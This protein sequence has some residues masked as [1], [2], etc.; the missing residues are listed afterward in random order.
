MLL[1]K[2]DSNFGISL[3]LLK[4]INSNIKINIEDNNKEKKKHKII[5]I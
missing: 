2:K 3:I 4:D 1:Y 5:V